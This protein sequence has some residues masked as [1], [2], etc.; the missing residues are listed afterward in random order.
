M[1]RSWGKFITFCTC[2]GLYF[3]TTTVS[4]YHKYQSYT[5]FKSYGRLNF[6]WAFHINFW[7]SWYIMG[8][9]WTSESKLLLVGIFPSLPCFILSVSIGFQTMRTSEGKVMVVCICDGLHFSTLSVSIYHKHLSDIRVKSYGRPNLRGHSISTFE[10]H[11]ILWASIGHPSQNF[12]PSE[13]AR[14]FLV[15]FWVPR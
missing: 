6:A 10:R 8:L 14:V 13:F 2:N 9:N 11:D 7:A 15:K 1:R 12:C 5:R 3:S 4:I